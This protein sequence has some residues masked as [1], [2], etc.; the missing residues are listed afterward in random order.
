MQHRILLLCF[1]LLNATNYAQTTAFAD[2]QKPYIEVVGHAEMEVVPDEIY[3]QFSLKEYEKDR[4]LQTIEMQ[5]KALTDALTAA[6]LPM[7]EINV[8][9][10]ESNFVR[11]NWGKKDFRAEKE[12][13]FKVSTMQETAKVFEV[14]DQLDISD[15]RIERVD[16]SQRKTFEDNMRIEATKN[17]KKIAN[18]MLSAIGQSVGNALF[19]GLNTGV[20]NVYPCRVD[21][22]EGLGQYYDVSNL[23]GGAVVQY[24][25]IKIA[26]VVSARFE[27]K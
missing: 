13:H 23:K 8:S 26:A 6:G 7:T 14:F 2:P 18:E 15:G 17:A 21:M 11:V 5:E 25:K 16:H 20:P 12:Y 1:A 27:I 4:V 10:F 9:E 24:Q 3:I 19:I 22:N